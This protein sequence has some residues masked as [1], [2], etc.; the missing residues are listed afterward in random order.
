MKNLSYTW[1]LELFRH[2][3]YIF[4]KKTFSD[5]IYLEIMLLTPAAV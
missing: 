3:L 2:I 4:K 1:T 5:D